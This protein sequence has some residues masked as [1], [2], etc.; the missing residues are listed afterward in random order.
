MNEESGVSEY[1]RRCLHIC[2][3]CADPKSVITF[4]TD[5]L[6]LMTT[7]GT[8]GGG[9]RVGSGAA[10]GFEGEIETSVS[11]VYDRRGPR[12]SPGIEVQGWFDPPPAGRPLTYPFEVGMQALGLGVRDVQEVISLSESFGA[13]RIGFGDTP[14]FVNLAATLKDPTGVSIDLVQE[15]SDGPSRLRHIR[16]SCVDMARSIEW[17]Q[18]IGFSVMSGPT[19]VTDGQLFGLGEEVD[20]ATARLRLIDQ[21]FEVLLTHWRKPAAEGRAYNEPNHAGLFRAAFA[22]E[23]INLAYQGLT[24]SGIQF[25]GPPTLIPPIAGTKVPELWVA[26]LRDPDGV[27]YELVERPRAVFVPRG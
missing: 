1:V 18:Q 7:P 25:E 11:F 17:Y 26:F 13:A 9:R 24:S 27:T 16:V 22:V 2:Y 6:G 23:D 4:L 20:V 5:G 15:T 14:L 10:L 8:K 21:D 12:V 3:C 19:S